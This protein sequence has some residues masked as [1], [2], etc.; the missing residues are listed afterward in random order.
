M[1]LTR[2]PAVDK[3][4]D[5]LKE[6]LREVEEAALTYTLADAMREGS[7]HIEQ[8]RGGFYDHN[9]AC[10]LSTAAMAVTARKRNNE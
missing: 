8:R 10:A 4:S 2:H 6:E 9:S 7:K 5:A 3:I 1:L